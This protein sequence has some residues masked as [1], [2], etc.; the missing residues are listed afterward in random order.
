M[1][2]RRNHRHEFK[3]KVAFDTLS[4]EWLLG[5]ARCHLQSLNFDKLFVVPES[6]V[7]SSSLLVAASTDPRERVEV[8]LL[9][10]FRCHF[11]KWVSFSDNDGVTLG[12]DPLRASS[13]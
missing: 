8:N 10:L 7:G 1:S 12:F 3:A 9:S 2:K 5:H 4:E 6:A 11:S 13:R